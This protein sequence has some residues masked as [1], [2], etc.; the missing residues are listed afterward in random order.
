[1][2]TLEISESPENPE[3]MEIKEN[4]YNLKNEVETDALEKNFWGLSLKKDWKYEVPWISRTAQTLRNKQFPEVIFGNCRLSRK[5]WSVLYPDSLVIPVNGAPKRE[6]H[7]ETFYSQRALPWWALEIPWRHVAED[8]TIRDKDWYIVV[9]APLKV[10]PKGTKIMTTL[11]PGKVYDT[12]F[13][14][15]KWIDIYVDW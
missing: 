13:M 3:F 15:G 11:W 10:Y 5:L 1:M 12:W 8:W 7:K 14:K 9:A 2:S 6:T 4:V